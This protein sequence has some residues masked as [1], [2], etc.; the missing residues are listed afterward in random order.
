LLGLGELAREWN[1]FETAD[2]YLSEG[3]ARVRQWGEIGA[4]DGYVSLARLRQAQGDAEGSLKII[5][6][7]R[8]LA[9]KF[10]ATDLDDFIVAA[11]E[12]RLWLAQGKIEAAARWLEAHGVKLD[13]G[14]AIWEEGDS[15]YAY[16]MRRY[17][18]I[19]LART[20]LA[21]DRPG[22][23]L[24]L[25]EELITTM[26]LRGSSRRRLTEVRILKALALQAE[27]DV[28]QALTILQEVLALAE[29]AGHVR[30]F[31]DEGEPMAR[32]LRQ[33]ASHRIMP[34]YANKL[35][36][37]F[38]GVKHD[39]EADMVRS[40]AAQALIDPLSARELEVLRLLAAGL[41]NP[42]IARELYIATST[43][44]S[45]VKNIFGKLNVHKR[46]DAVQRAEELALL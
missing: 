22:S 39:D 28:D 15:F 33:A 34:V 44:R 32:L 11:Q 43:V 27:A 25:L 42:E 10:D 19:L 12:V 9:E 8:L 18:Y 21:Q 20:L 41:S 35:L 2:A 24:T 6:E 17:E 37:A 30:T 16:H 7:A 36:A 23:A 31:A 4:M 29:P 26:E 5:Q 3:I 1:D 46:W 13:D 45:H 40:Q 38:D 14:S